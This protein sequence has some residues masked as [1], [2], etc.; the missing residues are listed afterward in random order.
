MLEL[1]ERCFHWDGLPK[2]IPINLPKVFP[3]GIRLFGCQ[4]HI[5]YRYSTGRTAF[6]NSRAIAISRNLKIFREFRPDASLLS[7]PTKVES[8]SIVIIDQQ[9]LF[10][11]ASILP[12]ETILTKLDLRGSIYAVLFGFRFDP[13]PRIVQF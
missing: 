1:K 7:E 3:I 4:S 6:Q 5:C 11:V 12:L 10:S 8:P 13:L 9:I 2:V